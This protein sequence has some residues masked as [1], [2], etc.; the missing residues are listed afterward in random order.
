[1]RYFNLKSKLRVSDVENLDFKDGVF[2]LVYSWGVLHHTPNTPAAIG[3]ILRVLKPGGQAK[4]MIYH[5]WSLVGFMLW[6]R[7]GLFSMKPFKGLS[8]I[9]SKHLE[10]PGTKAYSVEEAFQLFAGFDEV[11]ITNELT[12]GDLL[13][14]GT[15]QRHEGIILS[16]VR[17][18]WPRFIIRKFFN[19]SG[20]FMLISAKKPDR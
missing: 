7:Y 15:G 20:L 16:F 18:I 11:K 10:S 5:K 3:H 13:T 9:Y 17:I 19:N 6:L 12:H 8:E 14:S 2:D 1:L 4:I